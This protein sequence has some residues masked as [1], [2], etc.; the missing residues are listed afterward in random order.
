MLFLIPDAQAK[1]NLGLNLSFDGLNFHDQRFANG[2]N[3]FS[4][5]PPDQG[6]S[7]AGGIVHSAEFTVG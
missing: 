5:E 7:G 3:Q 4:V 6:M 1:S 2:G